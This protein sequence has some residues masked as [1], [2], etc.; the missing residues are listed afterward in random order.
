MCHIKEINNKFI[1]NQ[2]NQRPSDAT[3]IKAVLCHQKIF[4]LLQ[5]SLLIDNASIFIHFLIAV[6]TLVIWK[7]NFDGVVLLDK[8]EIIGHNC[9]YFLSATN[10]LMHNI[11]CIFCV[12]GIIFYANRSIW[13]KFLKETNLWEFNKIT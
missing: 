11:Y 2:I 7:D 10:Y 5:F 4:T 3:K 9:N 12:K 8:G 6:L 1:L 13:R